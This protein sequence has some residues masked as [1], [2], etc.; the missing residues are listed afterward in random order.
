MLRKVVGLYLDGA[1]RLLDDMRG[2]LANRDAH[3]LRDA[4]HTLK[5]SSANLGAV[6]LTQACRG[7]E[8][9]ARNQQWDGTQSMV[10][11]I[12]LE[13]EQVRGALEA[14]CREP[15]VQSAGEAT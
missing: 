2:A 1:P 4:A 15:G 9:T 5:S 10:D 8:T 14:M 12:A 3:G 7:L 11:A 6:A 13:F